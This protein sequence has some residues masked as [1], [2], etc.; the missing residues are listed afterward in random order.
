MSIPQRFVSK[1]AL[2]AILFASLLAGLLTGCA[3]DEPRSRS[4]NAPRE[5]GPND[6]RA[7]VNETVR[8]S[9]PSKD[10]GINRRT[11]TEDDMYSRERYYDPHH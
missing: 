8:E 9:A 1:S 4:S 11:Y 6:N 7:V 10:L 5:D 2:F 3:S